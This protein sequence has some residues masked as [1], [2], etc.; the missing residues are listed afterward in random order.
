MNLYFNGDE[1]KNIIPMNNIENILF[2]RTF[3]DV[4]AGGPVPPLG[5]LY[6]SSAIQ[7]AYHS[8]IDI[9][10]LDTGINSL[11]IEDIETEIK[12]YSP[13]LVG[14]STLSC[15]A[16]LMHQLA[17]SVKKINKQI[18]I[19]AGG[20]HPTVAYQQVLQDENIDYAVI[21]EAELTIVDLLSALKKGSNVSNVKGI[22]FRH[23][24]QIKST[25]PR[26]YITDLDDLAFPAWD[27][28]DIK[29]YAKYPNWN[30]ELKEKYYMPIFTSR[31]CPYKCIYC[32]TTLGKN[33][34]TRSPENIFSEMK[35]VCQN[36]GI[37]EFHVFDDIFNLDNE[38]SKR[39][40][41]QI[42]NS[43]LKFSLSFPNG[44]RMDIMDKGLIELMRKAGV[45]KIHCAIETVTP[46]IRRM[47]KKNLDLEAAKKFIKNSV[48]S[49]IITAG[50]FMLG[51]PGETK[52]EML[53][54]I[55]FAANSD[56]DLAYFFKVTPFPGTELYKMVAEKEKTENFSDLFFFSKHRS[57][58]DIPDEELNE[59]IMLAQK[60]F[61]LN[62]KRILKLLWRSPHKANSLKNI[63]MVWTMLLQAYC[64]KKLSVKG[65]L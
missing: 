22:A 55:D 40:C 29:E 33:Y 21:G 26:E 31:G 64:V 24:G 42:I 45:Y 57:C 4:G 13:Q 37:K 63:F 9:K 1:S 54:T 52:Q 34:R 58:A 41:K 56:L 65:N 20:P 32:H 23:E 3:K 18:K 14:F 6:L 27:L 61:Y 49:G 38:R 11:S 12:G 48:D 8:A 25:E 15:E 47:I 17:E 2:I 10:I 16:D 5:L 46:R 39:L 50:Y 7:R 30:G 62:P 19:L 44:L 59:L 35:L 36:Y 53:E 51:F 43:K 60:K 28:V